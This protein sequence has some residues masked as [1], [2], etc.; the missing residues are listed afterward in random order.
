MKIDVLSLVGEILVTVQSPTSCP[1][2]SQLDLK[3]KVTLIPIIQNPTPLRD[4]Q[5][6]AVNYL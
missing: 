3:D 1:P 5:I 6:N 4:F 2:A